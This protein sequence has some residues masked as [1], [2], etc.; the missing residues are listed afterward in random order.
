MRTAEGA[1]LTL[2]SVFLHFLHLSNALS[3]ITDE[4]CAVLLTRRRE[5]NQ[6][7]ML[8]ARIG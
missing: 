7:F 6:N 2:Y 5:H 3:Q 1:V 8:T 4:P